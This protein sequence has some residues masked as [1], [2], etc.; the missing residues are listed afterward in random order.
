MIQHHKM[1]TNHAYKTQKAKSRTTSTEAYLQSN[2]EDRD[3]RCHR[4]YKGTERAFGQ[5]ESSILCLGHI[6]V[7]QRFQCSKATHHAVNITYS[8][9]VR[10][11]RSSLRRRHHRHPHHHRH[12]RHHHHPHHRHHHHRH[13]HR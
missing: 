13:H 9:R 6:L 7:Q 4:N 12:R 10:F 3:Y 5:K 2:C 8:V 1:N 11:K